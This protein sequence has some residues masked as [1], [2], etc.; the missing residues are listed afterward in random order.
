MNNPFVFE[1]TNHSST[2][3]M[4]QIRFQRKNKRVPRR[5]HSANSDPTGNGQ[6]ELIS[7]CWLERKHVRSQIL[8]CPELS[9]ANHHAWVS[10]H[11]NVY[12]HRLSSVLRNHHIL[13][14]L[15]NLGPRKFRNGLQ[16]SCDPSGRGEIPGVFE[17]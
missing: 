15:W 11:K 4:V 13:E 8:L 17:C 12:C 16:S 14:R 10:H 9:E 5:I 6:S 3:V 7:S 2:L 1:W